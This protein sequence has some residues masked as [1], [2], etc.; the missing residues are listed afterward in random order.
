MNE[1]EDAKGRVRNQE[2]VACN[3]NVFWPNFQ[4][5]DDARMVPK[6]AKTMNEKDLKRK[7][8]VGR[9]GAKKMKI[10]Y[11]VR[12]QLKIFVFRKRQRAQN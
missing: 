9:T 1:L 3:I 5:R 11:Q 10:W 8:K 4:K 6:A 12:I 2:N 7:E